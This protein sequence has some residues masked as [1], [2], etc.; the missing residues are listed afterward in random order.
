MTI[1][2]QVEDLAKDVTEQLHDRA[3]CM[4]LTVALDES[5]DIIDTA[6]LLV[7]VRAVN[8]HFYSNSR[9]GRVSLDA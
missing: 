6:Q 4:Y 7:Y 3:S 8:G 2:C 5:T 1:Q 9:I